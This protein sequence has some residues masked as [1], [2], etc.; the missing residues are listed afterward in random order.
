MQFSDRVTKQIDLHFSATAE[1]VTFRKSLL[2][3][4]QTLRAN[5]KGKVSKHFLI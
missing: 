2:V 1:G 3:S 4:G 5:L